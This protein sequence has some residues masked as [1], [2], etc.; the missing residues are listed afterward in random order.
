MYFFINI[1]LYF[2]SSRLIQGQAKLAKNRKYNDRREANYLFILQKL[3]G[4]QSLYLRYIML[5]GIMKY[6]LHIEYKNCTKEERI[7]KLTALISHLQ[8]Q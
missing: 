1:F 5:K 2:Q 7:Y 6:E 8:V 4:I 3:V